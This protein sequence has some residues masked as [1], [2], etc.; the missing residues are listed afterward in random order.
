M[1]LDVTSLRDEYLIFHASWE[2]IIIQDFIIIQ[3]FMSCMHTNIS[4]CCGNV[5]R[6]LQMHLEVLKLMKNTAPC[7]PSWT[8][9]WVH[10]SS[11][12]QTLGVRT[13]TLPLLVGLGSS[14]AALSQ[15]SN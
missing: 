12:V 1:L 6:I 11:C 5:R 2:S 4:G 9:N 10:S 3:V 13:L 7:G 14:V 8:N 15:L